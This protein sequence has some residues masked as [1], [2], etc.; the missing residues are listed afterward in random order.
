MIAKHG[1]WH[2][3]DLTVNVPNPCCMTATYLPFSWQSMENDDL[4]LFEFKTKNRMHNFYKDLRIFLIGAFSLREEH[5]ELISSCIHNLTDSITIGAA[6]FFLYLVSRF[7][8]VLGDAYPS[9]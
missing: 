6:A 5:W 2:H 3:K 7:R 8:Y 4:A 9:T 1:T